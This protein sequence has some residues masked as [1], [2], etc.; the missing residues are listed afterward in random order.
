[1]SL[2]LPPL[3]ST[4]H[5]Y[6]VLRHCDCVTAS[7]WKPHRYF[8]T[9]LEGKHRNYGSKLKV[10]KTHRGD[11]YVF[12]SFS[13]RVFFTAVVHE[14]FT[15]THLEGL[16]EVRSI[17]EATA[18]T[19]ADTEGKQKTSSAEPEPENKQKAEAAT[20]DPEGEQSS[21]K[22][23]EQVTEPGPAEAATSPEEEQLKPRTRTSAGKGL[24][25]LFSS[26]LKRRSQCSEE[27]VF[28]AEKAKDEKADKEE[29]VDK[30]EEEKVE[31]GKSQDKEA[32]A[33][34]EKPEVKEVKKKDDKAEPKEE[35]KNV[36]EKVEKKDCL[37]CPCDN[38][39]P[40][41]LTLMEKRYYRLSEVL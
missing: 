13:R 24:S 38:K 31:E 32:K 7:L 1:M 36:E 9:S 18:V 20:S 21:T 8:P 27:E 16:C 3:I 15:A 6:L 10:E 25:R 39:I 11:C 17:C 14:E 35:K 4:H 37:Q 5:Q 26:F 2:R 34:E 19:E 29:K 40:G 12:R 30:K 22:A 23:Q 41:S 33:E 28:E